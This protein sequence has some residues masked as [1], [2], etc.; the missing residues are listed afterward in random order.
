MICRGAPAG[1]MRTE[2]KIDFHTLLLALRG[3]GVLIDKSQLAID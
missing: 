1:K 3:P 2:V